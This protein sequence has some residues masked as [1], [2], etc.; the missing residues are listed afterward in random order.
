[1]T[2]ATIILL[3]MGRRIGLRE[4]LLIKEPWGNA[5]GRSSKNSPANDV[6]LHLLLRFLVLLYFI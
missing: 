3:A 4:R 6:F 5:T 1:M 2:T